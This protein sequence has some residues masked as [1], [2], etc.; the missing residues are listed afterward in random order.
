MIRHA[1]ILAGGKGTRLRSVIEDIPKP[2][3]DIKGK[4]FLHYLIL[5]LQRHGIEEITL[6]VGYKRDV[7]IE[8][9]GSQYL[10]VKI[11]YLIEETPRGTGG[12]IAEVCKNCNENILLINGD[13]FVNFDLAKMYQ[14]HLN[15]NSEIT[16]GAVKIEH[17]KRYGILEFENDK[18]LA[19]NEKKEGED[20]YINGG[21]YL[22]NSSVFH[23]L[24]LPYECSFEKDFLEKYISTFNINAF[25][26][27]D[28]F[29]DI[30]IPEDYKSAQE[31]IP[32]F[33]VP[34]IDLTWTLFVDRDGVL[35]TYQPKDYVKNIDEFVWIEG[36]CEALAILSKIFGRTF[37]VTNQQGVGKGLMTTMELEK[38]HFKLQEDVKSM[39]GR[40]DEIYYCPHLAAYKPNCRKPKIGMA[41]K[42]KL[43]YPEIDLKK[44]VMIGDMASDMM[45][46]RTLGAY[47]ILIENKKIE[48]PIDKSLYDMKFENLYELYKSSLF[49]N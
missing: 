1:Y 19:F 14:T 13:T 7:I 43:D 29:I 16:I 46:G 17:P 31:L 21:I 40:V 36:S 11:N 24:D 3:A 8:Y 22:F 48:T 20:A 37:V 30:G 42:A 27:H 33:F 38:I 35:N 12:L 5:Q 18:I 47:N 49:R 32:A 39:G 41:L 45:F 2:M 28:F 23:N 44:T 9:F 25:K 10:S 34:K 4:P 15:S 26:I 6:I